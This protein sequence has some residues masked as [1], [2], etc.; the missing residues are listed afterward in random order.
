MHK[1]DSL[2]REALRYNPLTPQGL[3]RQVVKPGGLTTPDGVYLPE[4]THV[5]SIVKNVHHDVDLFGSSANEFDPLRYYNIAAI[6][7]ESQKSAVRIGS[8]FLSWGLG[9]H[10][11][12]GRFFAVHV[13]KLMLGHL[14]ERYDLEPLKKRPKTVQIGDME[15]PS[16]EAV[17]RMRRRKCDPDDVRK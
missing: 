15:F 16:E 11:C 4:G 5:H 6:N 8:D 17:V 13:M 2:I 1:L 3:V 12:P 10:A 7:Q 9:R 14:F